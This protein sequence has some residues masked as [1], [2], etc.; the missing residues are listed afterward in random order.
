M[1]SL[2]VGGVVRLHSSTRSA[3]LVLSAADLAGVPGMGRRGRML[4]GDVVGVAMV[5]GDLTINC[6]GAGCT[7]G[8]TLMG[9]KVRIFTVSWK[10]TLG[11]CGWGVV[12]LLGL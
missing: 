3:M 11:A 5:I 9:S 2:F 4:S 12:V 1:L 10:F 7:R 6:V 8:V